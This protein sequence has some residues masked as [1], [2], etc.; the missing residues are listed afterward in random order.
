MSTFVLKREYALA[1]PSSYV[2]IDRDEMEYV[3]GGS[4]T[5]S[6]YYN[7]KGLFHAIINAGTGAIAVY[8]SVKGLLTV[9]ELAAKKA[10]K[11]CVSGIFGYANLVYNAVQIALA[12]TYLNRYGTFSVVGKGIGSWT[13]YSYVAR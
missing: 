11:S 10:L 12:C 8:T 4:T 5:V 1:M 7:L 2:D 13:I 9:T 6:R 3:D